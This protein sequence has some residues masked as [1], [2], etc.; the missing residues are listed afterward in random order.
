MATLSNQ[1]PTVAAWVWQYLIS[2][3]E[4][5]H[6]HSEGEGEQCCCA[7]L[8]IRAF[9]GS[10]ATRVLSSPGN[11]HRGLV[12]RQQGSFYPIFFFWSLK[13][14]TG[15]ES[16]DMVCTSHALSHKHKLRLDIGKM[17]DSC[18]FHFLSQSLLSGLWFSPCSGWRRWQARSV[19][20]SGS[21]HS[22]IKPTIQC[23]EKAIYR[24][25]IIR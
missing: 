4:N 8:F 16:M 10:L 17:S 12:H 24:F 11:K 20:Q 19:Q 13:D 18:F 7:V 5:T 6:T 25:T 3:S 21:L 22:R 1:G 2:H 23:S 14:L 9:V 15:V